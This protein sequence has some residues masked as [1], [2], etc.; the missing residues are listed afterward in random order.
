MADTLWRRILVVLNS[1][2]IF[3][4]NIAKSP[5][6]CCVKPLISSLSQG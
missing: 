4:G 3:V 2:L 6:D 5:H 1:L